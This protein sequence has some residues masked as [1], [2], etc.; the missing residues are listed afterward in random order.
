METLTIERV[1]PYMMFYDKLS[2]YVNKYICRG[3]EMTRRAVLKHLAP[4][5]S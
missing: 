4:A 3:F 5:L 1:F 2:K